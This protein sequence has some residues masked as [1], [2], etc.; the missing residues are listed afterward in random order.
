M[1]WPVRRVAADVSRGLFHREWPVLGLT[2]IDEPDR[3]DKS[4]NHSN[5]VV[6]ERDFGVVLA[7]L[8]KRTRG[9]TV[10]GPSYPILRGAQYGQVS[11]ISS[12]IGSNNYADP[13]FPY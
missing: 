6:A 13:L 7:W 10:L 3:N 5:S 8:P 9:S 4:K 2:S 1:L 11:C 12:W